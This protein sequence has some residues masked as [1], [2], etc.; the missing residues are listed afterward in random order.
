[1]DFDCDQRPEYI[2]QGVRLEVR[3]QSE[4]LNSSSTWFPIRYYTPSVEVP[5]EYVSLVELDSSMN[6]V[7]VLEDLYNTSLTLMVIS[8][9]LFQ[10]L[11]IREYICGQI[12]QN[13]T[14]DTQLELR[15]LQRYGRTANVGTEANWFLDNINIR[16]WNGTSFLQ[17]LS[18]DF[19]S[20]Q[21]MLIEPYTVQSAV[22][23]MQRCGLGLS[24]SDRYVEFRGGNMMLGITRR[25]INILIHPIDI[26][27]SSEE[28][29]ECK[30]RCCYLDVVVAILHEVTE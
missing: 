25:S 23:T 5:S 1:M 18:E 24:P 12:V 10:F 6:S 26:F 11:T 28:S 29:S 17:V 27:V 7:T 19:N 13:L 2:D 4:S 30:L 16:I 15:W 14:Q 8:S 3:L 9:G 22:I 20:D 21:L